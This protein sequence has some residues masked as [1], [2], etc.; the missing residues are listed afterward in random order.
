VGLLGDLT[1]ERG[2][3]IVMSTHDIDTV[4]EF[5]DYAY[6][7]QPGGRIAL[8]GTPAEV[9]ARAEAMAASNIRPPVLAALFAKLRVLDASAPDTELTVDDAAEALEAWR[10]GAA[11]A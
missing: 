5:A 9:F 11:R 10:R 6:V 8:K 2:L 7:L 4:P 1:D 3:T